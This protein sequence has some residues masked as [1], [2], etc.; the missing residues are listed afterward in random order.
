MTV[1]GNPQT[2]DSILDIVLSII[3]LLLG[4]SLIILY[5]RYR[6]EENKNI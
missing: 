5:I 4:L 3:G 1:A 6:R 2:G